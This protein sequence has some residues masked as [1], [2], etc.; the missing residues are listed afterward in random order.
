[1]AETRLQKKWNLGAAGKLRE[2]CSETT[3]HGFGRLAS[4]SSAI[5]RLIWLVCLVSALTY[6]FV[7]GFRLVSDYFS[8]PVDV[9]VTMKHTEDLEF[10][11]I[12]VCNMNAIR[13]QALHEVAKKPIWK[14]AGSQNG[15]LQ[16]LKSYK[17]ALLASLDN[18]VK[19]SIGHQAEDFILECNWKGENCGPENFTWFGNYE[20]GNCYVFGAG[21]M[22]QNIS[23]P[24][25]QNGLSLLLN[26]EA[27]EYL[28]DFSESYGA[29]VEVANG[30]EV[31]FPEENGYLVA[32]GQI[33]NIGFSARMVKR[34][35]FPYEGTYCGYP[36][37]KSQV[38]YSYSQMACFKSCYAENQKKECGCADI[39]YPVTP[40]CNPLNSTQDRCLREVN[41]KIRLSNIKCLCNEDCKLIEFL[42]STSSAL[43]PTDGYLTR[44]RSILGNK[45]SNVTSTLSE[46]RRN[47]ARVHI[48]YKSMT[49]E[50]I[51]QR[52]RYQFK[53]L[54]SNVGGS[55]GLFTGISLLT[56]AEFV[57]LMFDL[58]RFSCKK[59]TSVASPMHDTN[60]KELENPCS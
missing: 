55:L 58:T 36:G 59:K 45:A 8:Y 27:D 38:P 51:A 5:E 53:D 60:E 57:K 7:Q 12:V 37:D 39:Q 21:N 1:M 47:L 34:L 42:V 43:W 23:A 46:A 25:N 13:K 6:T 35:D 44:L 15:S 28:G 2:F 11:A 33:T 32:P 17:R 56:L 40:H 41:V 22:T 50:V 48:F 52:P 29:V 20:Y 16:K 9:K 3:A 31:F 14:Q 49:V 26:I 4:S 54:I 10:P 30:K 24:G 19:R 18:D